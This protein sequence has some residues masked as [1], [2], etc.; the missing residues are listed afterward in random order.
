TAANR[1]YAFS[2]GLA[3]WILILGLAIRLVLAPL[4]TYPFD[5]E[6]WGVILQNTE[7][8]NGL[9]GLTGYFY[10]PAWGYIL[11]FEDLIINLLPGMTYGERFTDL[12]EIEGMVFPYQ[13]ATTTTPVFN[14]A[15]KLPLILVDVLV[16]YLI[17]RLVMS[18]CGDERKAA[19]G[20]GLWFLC[21]I[22]I[23]M[24]SVQAQFDCISA[25]LTLLCVLLV[26]R[27][28]FF[29][30]GVIF[31]I[32]AL[33]KFFPAFCIFLLCVYVVKA[34]PG[35]LSWK[36]LLLS[37]SGAVLTALVI[38]LPQILDGTVMNAFS[39]VFGRTSEY[40]LMQMLRTYP[41][42]AVTLVMLVV[43]AIFAWRMDDARRKQD[44]LVLILAMLSICTIFSPGPQYWIVYLP[45]LSYYIACRDRNRALLICLIA[46]AILTTTA[47][48]FN[49]SFSL[50]TTAAEYLHLCEPQTVIS[51][52]HALDT[53]VFGTPFTQLVVFIVEFIQLIIMILIALFLLSDLGLFDRYNKLNE[54]ITEL[55]TKLGGEIRG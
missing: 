46:M 22:V 17:Y 19:I 53:P 32:A 2:A 51:W 47:A 42:I 37:V 4:F 33:I 36:N 3:L 35:R 25:L 43:L 27:N 41:F 11:G 31:T 28:L 5:I 54:F 10:T 18:E 6:H 1:K 26:K 29:L 12:L 34:T 38:F 7:S 9:F 21:P 30:A 24:S 44:F 15:M 14:F 49:N 48:F 20:F 55:R 52:M 23:Y 39:F 40:D 45:L 8:G 13:T 16:G 50:L